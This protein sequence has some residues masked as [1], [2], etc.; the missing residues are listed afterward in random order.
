MAVFL[1][2][3]SVNIWQG[4]NGQDL[5]CFIVRGASVLREDESMLL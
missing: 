3:P 2:L 1:G 5:D 4:C